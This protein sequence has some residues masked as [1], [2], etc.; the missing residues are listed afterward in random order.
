MLI[1]K[2]ITDRALAIGETKLTLAPISLKI[3]ICEKKLLIIRYSGV[4][5]GWGTPIIIDVVIYS[6][7]SHKDTV[8][9]IVKK[10]IKNGTENDKKVNML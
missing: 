4:P 3:G 7:Q 2:N 5:G 8:G 9:A 1:Y 10:Y 6:P